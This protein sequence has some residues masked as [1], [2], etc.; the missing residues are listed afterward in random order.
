MITFNGTDLSPYLIVNDIKRPILPDQELTTLSIPGRQGA[1][2]FYKQKGA[3]IIQVDV[4]IK[5]K[6]RAELREKIRTIADILDT[7]DELTG[8]LIFADEPDK[9]VMAA[10]EGSTDLNEIYKTGQGTLTFYAPDPY[11]YALSD[12]VFIYTTPG[13]YTFTRKGT[14]PSYPLI[15]IQGTNSGGVITI[16]S[17][18]VNT[19]KFDGDLKTGEKLFLD[20]NLITAYIEKTTGEKVS[21]MDKLD[22]LDFPVLKKGENTVTVSVENGATVTSVNIKCNSRWK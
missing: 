22:N 5:A 12:D 6:D 8:Q 19:I 3:L 2:L 11:Y 4:T 21:V 7:D 20:S 15:E 18:D 9:Y 14:A 10:I 16:S 13:S 17:N 1:F